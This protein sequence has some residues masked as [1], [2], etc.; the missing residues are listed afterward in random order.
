MDKRFSDLPPAEALNGGDILAISQQTEQGL[1]SKRAS[2]DQLKGL[3]AQSVVHIKDGETL[4]ASMADTGVYIFD[5]GST[6]LH[7]PSDSKVL[8][9]VQARLEVIE[10]GQWMRLS[11][12][13]HYNQSSGY[14]HTVM[15]EYFPELINGNYDIWSFVGP[16]SS[17]NP[18]A[19][20]S[21]VMGDTSKVSTLLPTFGL[22]DSGEAR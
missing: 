9:V 20:D 22:N 14:M 3:V 12:W 19:G 1:A 21:W 13:V 17:E 5:T 7:A 10:K 11:A 8:S 16:G 18:A 4:D 6:L 2:L 15:Y